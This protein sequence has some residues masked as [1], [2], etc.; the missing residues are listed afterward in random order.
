MGVMRYILVLQWHGSTEADFEAL[1]HMEDLLE[2][3]FGGAGSLDGHDFG[4]GEMN[5]FIETEEPSQAFAT[6]KEILSVCPA[7]AYVRAAF[8]EANGEI[9]EVLW[10]LDLTTFSIK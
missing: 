7:W 3:R 2:S 4:S 6:A 5:I 10:P 9:Y 8:R 1:V